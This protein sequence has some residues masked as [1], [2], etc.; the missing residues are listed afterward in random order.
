MYTVCT[1]L[2]KQHE[3]KKFSFFMY[4]LQTHAPYHKGNWIT[5]EHKNG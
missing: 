4:L 5:Q 3:I 2:F 1:T